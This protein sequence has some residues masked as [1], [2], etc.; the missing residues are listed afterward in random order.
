M[1]FLEKDLEQIIYESDTYSL[2]NRGIF[3]TGR[4]FRQLRI[5]NYGVADLVTFDRPFLHSHFKKQ[6]RGRITVFELKKDAI[7]V[8]AF[9]QAVRYVRGIQRWMQKYHPHLLDRI[10]F[11]IV[12]V[13]NECSGDVV[14]LNNIFQ[15]E[16]S[17]RLVD[18]FPVCSISIYR[19]NY[20]F[21]GISFE[22]VSDYFLTEEGF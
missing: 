18:E 4:R 17:E 7:S 10:D 6:C 11:N 1:K 20:D 8:S 16:T 15:L 14:Y 21:D 2:A 19:Y 3:V 13:G 22:D 9:F 5:G 12:L